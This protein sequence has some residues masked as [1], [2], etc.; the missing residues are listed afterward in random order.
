MWITPEALGMCTAALIVALV[1]ACIALVMVLKMLK[2]KDAQIAEAVA[3]ATAAATAARPAPEPAIDE[4]TY[5]VLVAAIT[6]E[7][8]LTGI[9]DVRVLSIT[10]LD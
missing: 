1:M 2:A 9:G 6:E 4:E 7:A 3:E 8:K 10:E 5:A